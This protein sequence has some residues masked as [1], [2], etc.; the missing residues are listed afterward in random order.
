M[1]G[2]LFL[3]VLSCVQEPTGVGNL[4]LDALLCLFQN[5]I[6][7]VPAAENPLIPSDAHLAGA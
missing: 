7:E 2:A 5:P 4:A 1:F 3:D 6:D